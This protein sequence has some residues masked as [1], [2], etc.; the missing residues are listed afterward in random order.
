MFFHNILRPSVHLFYLLVLFDILLPLRVLFTL[1]CENSAL[2]IVDILQNY[3]TLKC[4]SLMIFTTTV[5][6]ICS[7]AA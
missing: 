4:I 5:N 1:L 7:S 3:A 6:L 2:Q